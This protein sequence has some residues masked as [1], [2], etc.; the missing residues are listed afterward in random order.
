[1]ETADG[2]RSQRTCRV[3]TQRPALCMLEAVAEHQL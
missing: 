2:W 1:V 3:T